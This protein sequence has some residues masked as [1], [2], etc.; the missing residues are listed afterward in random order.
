D[1][2]PGNPP[3]RDPPP[4]NPPPRDPPPGDPPPGPPPADPPPTTQPPAAPPT[5]PPGAPTNACPE[6]GCDGAV[7]PHVCEGP[8]GASNPHC[9]DRRPARS[10]GGGALL[11]AH[12]VGLRH[13]PPHRRDD[14]VGN[15]LCR[16]VRVLTRGPVDDDL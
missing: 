16:R 15:R 14:L 3:P 6:G 5:A 7:P 8:A 12:A 1:P 9:R 2:P 10:G 13:R 11:R 4:S